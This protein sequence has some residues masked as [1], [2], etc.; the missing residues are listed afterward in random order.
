MGPTG[1][2]VGQTEVKLGLSWVL[3]GQTGVLVG[4]TGVKVGLSWVIVGQH[5]VIMGLSLKFWPEIL[6]C[7]DSSVSRASAS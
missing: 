5:G 4:Q 2:L 3:V 7:A 6:L 1:V